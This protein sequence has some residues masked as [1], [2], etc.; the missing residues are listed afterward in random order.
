[1][2]FKRHLFWFLVDFKCVLDVK[3]GSA[4]IYSIII[5][6]PECILSLFGLASQLPNMTATTATSLKVDEMSI[7]H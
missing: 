4:C 1:M 5:N 2:S 3:S 6:K 7:Q